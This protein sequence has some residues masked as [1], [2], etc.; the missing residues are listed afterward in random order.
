[1][2]GSMAWLLVAGEAAFRAGSTRD[3]ARGVTAIT[4]SDVPQGVS[5]FHGSEEQ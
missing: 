4:V 3:A 5:Y 2:P 1:M